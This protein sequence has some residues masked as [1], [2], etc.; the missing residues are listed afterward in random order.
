MSKLPQTY[1]GEAI[2]LIGVIYGQ[3]DADKLHHK[4]QCKDCGFIWQHSRSKLS[5]STNT[6]AHA[7]PVC[8]RPEYLIY[9]G[10]KESTCIWSGKENLETNKAFCLV[11]QTAITERLK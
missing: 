11:R 8:S 6:H 4:H 10:K 1:T 9:D 2:A 5:E 3:E 7:C